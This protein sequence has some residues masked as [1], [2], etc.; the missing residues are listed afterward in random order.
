[1]GNYYLDIETTG[2]DPDVDEILTIQYQELERYTG[3]AIGPL[4]ILKAWESS[5]KEIIERFLRDS[6]FS[7]AYA[8]SFISVGY[9]LVFEHN[10]LKARSAKYGLPEIDILNKPFIDLHTIGIMMNRGEFKGSGL[11]KITGKDRDGMMVPV[12]N[13]VG[14]YDKIVEY[15]EMETREFVKFNVW[16]YKRMPELLKEWMG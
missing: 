1:M 5:E 6:N 15:I 11:D 2:L 14:D 3:E 9:N 16:L 4:V 13:K 8:F 7:D 12:W 10:F